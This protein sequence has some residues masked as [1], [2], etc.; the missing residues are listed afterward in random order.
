M[1]ENREKDKYTESTPQQPAFWKG[2]FGGIVGSIMVI[3]LVVFVAFSSPSQMQQAFS[4][5]DQTE[6]APTPALSDFEETVIS[7]INQSSEAVVSV[8]NM[9][10][11]MSGQNGMQGMYYGSDNGIEL[12]GESD[13]LQMVSQGSG[14]IYKIDGDTAYIVTNHHVVAGSQALEIRLADGTTVDGELIGSDEMSDLAVLMIDAT[15]VTTAMKFADSDQLQVGSLAL[16]IG[17][18]LSSDFATSVTQ[19]IVSGLQR[20]IPIDLDGDY[21]ED[22]N[23]TLLQT[24]AAINPG[25]SGGALV[26]S[27]GQLIGI[28]S[29]KFAA[30]GVEGMG[31]AIPSNDVQEIISQLET[32]G[33]V[34]RPVLGVSTLDVDM[35]SENSRVNVLG[36]SPDFTS[37]VVVMEVV[38]N[39]SAAAGGVEEYDVITAINGNEIVTYT[40]LRQELYSH[41]VGDSIE[42]T[43]LRNGEEI[44]LNITLEASYSDGGLILNQ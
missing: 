43:V 6:T 35:L 34:V 40:D 1:T 10:L 44:Q 5:E 32:N 27:S 18:P 15:N 14:V 12:P 39:S 2:L 13:N 36:L 11:I 21:R 8:G 38:P 23:M 33:E 31:F 41:Q 30:T 42:V 24:D 9:Q 7:A 3:A 16:A 37:G 17:S 28:N 22:W 20:S 25:N 19:G 26:N 4:Q 29:S